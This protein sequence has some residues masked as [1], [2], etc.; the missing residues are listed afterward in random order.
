[1]AGYLFG[2]VVDDKISSNFHAD[3]HQT[4]DYFM[5]YG[6]NTESKRQEYLRRLCRAVV[7]H[8]GKRAVDFLKLG[9]DGEAPIGNY[10]LRGWTTNSNTLIAAAAYLGHNRFFE[11][12]DPEKEINSA[13]NFFFGGPLQ[14]AAGEGHLEIVRQ[15][16]D[17]GV[18]PNK[19]DVLANAA[20]GGHEKVVHLLF[21][22]KYKLK[23]EGSYYVDAIQS[24]ASAGHAEIVKFLL[25]NRKRIP[26][27]ELI[28]LQNIIIME[29]AEHGHEAVVSLA[30]ASA[31][32]LKYTSGK[33]SPTS[34]LIVAA[35]RGYVDVIK[36]L[37]DNGADPVVR[38][39]GKTSVTMAAAKGYLG[40][41]KVLLDRCKNRDE[42]RETAL[43]VA[44]GE[45]QVH[46]VMF[47]LHQ[48]QPESQMGIVQRAFLRAVRYN[49]VMTVRAMMAYGI[50]P[51]AYSD[52]TAN[53]PVLVAII[54]DLED[55]VELLIDAGA[56]DLDKGVAHRALCEAARRGDG[57]AVRHLVKYGVD[58]NA[59]SSEIGTTPWLEACKFD[60][61]RQLLS[62]KL[63]AEYLVQLGAC[64]NPR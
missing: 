44:A 22:P 51:A 55:M 7:N 19:P 63:F 37:L 38:L 36:F 58:I 62:T 42:Q 54:A 4:V 30:L 28:Y 57:S 48:I 8:R 41:L 29:G 16:L 12:L 17:R 35:S 20:S 64:P 18:S 47:L 5:K 40:A 33:P 11:E 53:N 24:A 59:Y 52:D 9:V 50:D 45:D 56:S 10:D 1:M 21:H 15:L 60:T 2:K 49:C 32:A 23:R 14:C 27:P 3:I 39:K 26:A 43:A 6:S 34:A 13:N 25:S 46:I 31:A 61:E